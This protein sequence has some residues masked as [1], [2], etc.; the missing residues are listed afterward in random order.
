MLGLVIYMVV[1][2]IVFFAPMILGWRYVARD[3]LGM[4]FCTSVMWPI[5]LPVLFVL[6]V[7][8]NYA[9]ATDRMAKRWEGRE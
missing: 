6:Y 9:D 4:V 1:A 8:D 7:V 2:V 5:L 3:A